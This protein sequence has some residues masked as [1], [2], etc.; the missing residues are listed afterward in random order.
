VFAE[1][2]VD[3]EPDYDTI[4]PLPS[5]EPDLNPVS[6]PYARSLSDDD[7]RPLPPVPRE[8]ATAHPNGYVDSGK[9]RKRGSSPAVSSRWQKKVNLSRSRL[10]TRS[11]SEPSLLE[12]EKGE[13][14]WFAAHFHSLECLDGKGSQKEKHCPKSSAFSRS[15]STS[16]VP[17]KTSIFTSKLLPRRRRTTSASSDANADNQKPLLPS[18]THAVI[19]QDGKSAAATEPVHPSPP[20]QPGSTTPKRKSPS[21]SRR[22]LSREM[23]RLIDVYQ[24]SNEA[25]HN[26]N[27]SS[28]PRRREAEDHA[29]PIHLVRCVRFYHPRK[30]TDNPV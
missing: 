20:T 28:S 7:R 6:V 18:T 26:S 12:S 24:S 1:I 2:A 19:S 27:S 16:S 23:Q 21:H 3:P 4:E 11:G 13:L 25:D 29:D 14:K 10:M 8:S 17:Q 9:Y 30:M 22:P 5:S 15:K